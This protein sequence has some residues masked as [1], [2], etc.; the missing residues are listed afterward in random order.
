MR[1]LAFCIC[2]NKD[3]DQLRSNCAADQHLCF[4]FMD[5]TIPLLPKFHDLT[6]EIPLVKAIIIFMSS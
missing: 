4:G 1:K 3:A 6:L 2:Q 5:S